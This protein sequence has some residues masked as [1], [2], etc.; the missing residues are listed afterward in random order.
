MI[1]SEIWRYPV[2]SMQGERLDRCRIDSRGV[3]HDRGFAVVDTAS[4]RALSAKQAAPLL[5]FAAR[6]VGQAGPVE[7]RFPDGIVLQ[8]DAAD[9]DRQ[10][11][12]ALGRAVTLAPGGPYFDDSPLHIVT[13]AALR[14]MGELASSGLE[15]RRRFRP[16]LVLA[17]D[18]GVAAFL[19][20][21]WLGS[22]IA[23]GTARLGVQSRTRRCI[24]TTHAQADLPHAPSVMKIMLAETEK[25]LG[26]YATIQTNGAVAVGDL[27]LCHRP[28]KA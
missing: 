18:S 20:F 3:P 25:C 16:N 9:I 22:Q 17:E 19:E 11:S 13:E 1:V 27:A 6:M 10:L 21:D 23:I 2:K 14:R 4:G 28:T 7:I 8:S 15:D 24:M 5:N 12:E 26:V